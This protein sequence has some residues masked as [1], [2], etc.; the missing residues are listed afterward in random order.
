MG[1]SSGRLKFLIFSLLAFVTLSFSFQNCGTSHFNTKDF[2]VNSEAQLDAASDANG[3]SNIPLGQQ[4]SPT[5]SI[6]PNPNPMPVPTPGPVLTSNISP[7]MPAG[8]KQIL[9]H[10]FTTREGNGCNAYYPGGSLLLSDPNEPSSPSG[11]MRDIKYA[12]AS[13]GGTMVDCV[14]PVKGEVY[15]AFTWRPSSPFGGYDN[16]AN[17]MVFY[18]SAIPNSSG[19]AWGS[20]YYGK[21]NGQRVVNFFLQGGGVNN[22]HV[23]NIYGDCADSTSM[24]FLPNVDTSPVLEGKWHRVEVYFKRS[25]TGSSKDGITKMWVDGSLRISHNNVNTPQYDW[26]S[27][28]TNH[29]WDGQCA[30]RNA[31]LPSTTY[32]NDCRPYD[33]YHDFGDF[34]VGAR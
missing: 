21:T 11:F 25:T 12:G 2:V 32:P 28:M 34:F 30:K 24:V 5:P 23:D 6:T 15:Y 17:K 7:N 16:G 10:D 13:E 20:H 18:I 3:D 4:P 33:D 26:T 8:M 31:S 9:H 29:T 14:H 27:I 19:G 1:Q 22:C